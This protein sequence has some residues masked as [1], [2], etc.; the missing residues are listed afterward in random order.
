MEDNLKSL[1]MRTKPVGKLLLTMSLP[2]ILSMLIQAL[3]NVVDTIFVAQYCG[4]DGITALSLAMPLQM[5]IIAF[6]IGIGVGA[7]AQIAKN[8]GEGKVEKA[9]ALAKTGVFM[10]IVMSL[11]FVVLGL[12]ISK[13]FMSIF[14]KNE[15]V[16]KMG[17]Q[18]LMVVVSLSFGSFIEITCSKIMQSTGNMRIPMI[19]QL[20]GAVTNI[21]LDPLLIFGFGI[22]PEL[23]VLGAAIATVI[24]QVFAMTFVLIMFFVR[25]HDVSISPRGFKLRKENV[26]GICIIGFPVMVMNA[27][28]SVTTTIMNGIV[29]RYEDGVAVLGIYFKL[30]SFVFMPVFG[31]TQGAMP[32][33]SYN[34]GAKNKKRFVKAFWLS[35]AAALSMMVIGFMLFQIFPR[36]LLLLFNAKGALMD[37]GVYALRVISYCF[38]PAAFGIVMTTTIQ[39]LG[40]GLPSLIMSLMRQLVLLIPIAALLGFWFGIKGIWFCYPISEALVF[41]AFLPVTLLSIKRKFAG[42]PDLVNAQEAVK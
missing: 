14:S 39:A 19:S 31:L 42:M 17:S 25:K 11:V 27:V 30:Q 10:A 23:G 3:Y 41:L 9:N 36:Q 37:E 1:K 7:N 13:P 18:Y 24:G 20:I 21:V 5:L 29:G 15:A 26:L 34:Y 8:L 28:A 4:N 6:A 38:I 32:I 40:K 33:L 2:A 35:I 22:F 16:V 12:T